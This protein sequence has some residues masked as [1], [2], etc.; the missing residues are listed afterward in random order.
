MT[1]SLGN[2]V[3]DNRTQRYRDLST[4]R[5]ISNDTIL[6]TLEKRI[7]TGMQNLER[8]L[9]AALDPNNSYTLDDYR[10][11]Y[12]TELK[13]LHIQMALVGV[14]G[15]NNATQSLYGKV[16]NTLKQE[17]RYLN[18]FIDDIVSGNL[19]PS[20]IKARQN[21]YANKIWNSYWL[22]RTD[23]AREVF[24]QERRVLQPAEHCD[25]CIALAAVGWQPIG[26]LPKPADGSTQCLSNCR[27]IMEYR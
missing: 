1:N 21:M 19:T 3:Y 4:G 2:I 17:Y 23:K 9:N 18:N 25:D 27:C 14:G 24:T 5:F 13:T 11:A 6:D 8:Y 10:D 15:K 7:D 22:A 16:G 20:Q 26:T 12:V